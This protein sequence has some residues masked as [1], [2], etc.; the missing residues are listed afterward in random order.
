MKEFQIMQGLF[1]LFP[2]Q[3]VELNPS[4]ALECGQDHVA[5]FPGTEYGEYSGET[6]QTLSWPGDEG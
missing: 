3:E 6:Q 4:I 2:L 1:P 5:Y